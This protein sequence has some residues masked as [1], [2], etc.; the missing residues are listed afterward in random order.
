M[1]HVNY[2]YLTIFV[3]Q[4]FNLHAQVFAGLLIITKFPPCLHTPVEAP[5][6]VSRTELLRVI[7][8]TTGIVLPLDN[9]LRLF[10]DYVLLTRSYTEATRILSFPYIQVENHVL[11]IVGWTPDYGSTA[12][13]LDESIPLE[14]QI[15]GR[16]QQPQGNNIPLSLLISGMPPQLFL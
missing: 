13:F 10:G 8:D 16:Q 1:A 9:V 6:S 4:E 3:E 12:L 15:Q 14:H 11:A 7:L 5:H 2:Q